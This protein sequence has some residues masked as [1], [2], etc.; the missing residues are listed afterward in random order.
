M[1]NTTFQN[2]D[3]AMK[4]A[5]EVCRRRRFPRIA[6]FYREVRSSQQEALRTFT[7]YQANL[8]TDPTEQVLLAQDIYKACDTLPTE[9]KQLLM[10][11]YWGDYVDEATYNKACQFLAYERQHGRH[12]RMAWRYSMRQVGV[13]AGRDDKYVGRHIH[14]ALQIIEAELAARD[15]IAGAHPSPASNPHACGLPRENIVTKK[16]IDK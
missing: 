3:H 5:T 12:G 13:W 16:C 4:W 10:A 8:P 11:H 2:A 15:L 9:D 14:K 7:G 6:A 1:Q